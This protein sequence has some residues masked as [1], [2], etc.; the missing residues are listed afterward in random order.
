MPIQKSFRTRSLSASLAASMFVID[1]RL[2][3]GRSST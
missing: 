2:A 3:K 1:V